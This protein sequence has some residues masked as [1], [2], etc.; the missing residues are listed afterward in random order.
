MP[1]EYRTHREGTGAEGRPWVLSG[2]RARN[3]GES[4]RSAR[5]P[6]PADSGQ[7]GRELERPLLES[8]E[9]AG[10][11]RTAINFYEDTPRLH[12]LAVLGRGTLLR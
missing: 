12:G 3:C 9:T 11:K 6:W 10:R 8:L 4:A 5:W 2:R 7:D 1:R